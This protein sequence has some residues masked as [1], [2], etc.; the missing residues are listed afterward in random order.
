MRSGDLMRKDARGFFYFA[1]RIGDSFRWK[2][3]NVSTFEVAQ[4][5]ARCPGV[6]DATVYGVAVPGHEGRAGMAALVV[7]AGFDL[8]AL[9]AHVETTLPSYARPL[10]VRLSE[11]LAVTETFKHKKQALHAQGFDPAEVEDRLY[12]AQHGLGYVALDAALHRRV[13]AGDI[14]L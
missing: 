14:R 4:A 5:L 13:C 8:G 9:R 12:L 7:E 2:G 11:T 1:D 3:E 10:F 6:R